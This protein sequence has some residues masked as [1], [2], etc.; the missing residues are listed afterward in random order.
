[1]NQYVNGNEFAECFPDN[2][3]TEILPEDAEPKNLLVYRVCISG[4]MVKLMLKPLK[5]LMKKGHLI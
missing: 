5:V 4:K 1:M 2:F 3:K